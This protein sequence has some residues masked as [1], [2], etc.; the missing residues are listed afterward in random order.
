MSMLNWN[1]KRVTAC[2]PLLFDSEL[3]AC[4]A[5]CKVLSYYSTICDSTRVVIQS[6]VVLRQEFPH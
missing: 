3:S 1:W 4:L 5:T 2:V 6:V